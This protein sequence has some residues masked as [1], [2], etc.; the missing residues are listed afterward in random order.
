MGGTETHRPEESEMGAIQATPVTASQLSQ[1]QSGAV[2]STVFHWWMQR[3]SQRSKLYAAEA[4]MRKSGV[5]LKP[6][7]SN[8]QV[9]STCTAIERAL[10]EAFKG[11]NYFAPDVQILALPQGVGGD[12]CPREGIRLSTDHANA[13]V[14]VHEYCHHIAATGIGAAHAPH[15]PE[16]A[17]LLLGLTSAVVGAE[18]A[19]YLKGGFQDEGVR[20]TPVR[21]L[22]RACARS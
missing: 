17:G 6:L 5:D 19:R 9:A 22:A 2:A 20:C 18:A 7:T 3:D 15:G 21:Q 16:F 14:L 10:P 13:Y 4:N 1:R 8:A 11:S 12:Y